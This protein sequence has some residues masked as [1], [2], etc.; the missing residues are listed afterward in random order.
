MSPSTGGRIPG[1]TVSALQQALAAEHAAVWV[2]GL[3]TAFLPEEYSHA[4]HRD[5]TAHRALRDH[6]T[7]VIKDAGA[8]PKP[9][10]AAYRTPQPVTDER[11]AAR[12]VATAES[13]AADAWQAVLRHSDPGS[14]QVRPMALDALSGAAVRGTAW[15]DAAGMAPAV[16]A[17]PGMH[18]A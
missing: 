5:R 12:A 1:E 18:T 8:A 2:Y 13:D 11:S 6:V 15:R 14:G 10:A 3:V 16:V 9:A 4:V 7:R 17:L